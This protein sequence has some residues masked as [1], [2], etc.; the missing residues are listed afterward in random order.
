MKILIIAGHGAGDSGA[1]G[2]GFKEADLTRQAASILEGKLKAYALTVSR[3]PSARNAYEDNKAGA[4][5][6]NFSNYGLIVELHFNS[7]NGSANGTE[8]L[9]KP[10]G[11]K[12]LAA[13]VSAAIASVGFYNRGAKQRTDLANMNKCAKLGV[14]YILVETCFID[15]REDMKLYEAHLY[16][17]WDKVAAAICSYYGIKKLASGGQPVDTNKTPTSNKKP[18]TERNKSL[19]AIDGYWGQATTRAAQKYLGTPVDGIV[20]N[21]PMVNKQYLP[22]CSTISWEFKQRGY[23]G[24]SSVV[25]AVQRMTGATVDGFFGKASVRALQKYLGV[26]VDGYCGEK[27]VKAFQK[28]LNSRVK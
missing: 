2:C 26:T 3:Y 14:P 27:T 1:V 24:G 13:K 12:A 16:S 21:Q 5:A 7:F 20:S 6:V 4:L 23:K 19:L 10:S 17:V 28:Y 11:M 15:N 25:R 22:R 9:Y 18:A 8:V